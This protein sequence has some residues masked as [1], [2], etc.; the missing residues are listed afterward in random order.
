MHQHGG[1][2]F[3]R[4]RHHLLFDGRQPL[5]SQ[6]NLFG[7]Q[8]GIGNVQRG[9]GFLVRFIQTYHFPAA[10]HFVVPCVVHSQVGGDAVKPGRKLGFRRVTLA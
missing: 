10:L 9:A 4:Q 6:N 5:P 1:T 2:L 7:I 3:F 8:R